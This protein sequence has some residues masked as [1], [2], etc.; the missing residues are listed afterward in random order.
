MHI[1]PFNWTKGGLS[2]P[3]IAELFSRQENLKAVFHG[4]DH[5]Q[6]NVKEYKRKYFFFD[7]HIAGNW[8]TIYRGYR[9]VEILKDGTIITY[10]MNPINEKTVNTKE[11]RHT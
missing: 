6:D 1:T 4:H 2:C 5:D 3:E 9:I 11:I 10:Q 8:G 7:S